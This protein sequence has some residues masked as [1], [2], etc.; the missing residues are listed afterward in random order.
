MNEI[1]ILE[2]QRELEK[3][4][5]PT[6][7]AISKEI[8]SFTKGNKEKIGKIFKRLKKNE[9]WEYIKGYT[10]FKGNKILV[11]KNVLIPRI[12]TEQLV[13]IA[14][15]NIG[16]IKGEKQIFDI[17]TGSSCI[18]ISLSKVF[19]EDIFAIDISKK[20]VEVAKKN[21]EVNNCKNI[22]LVN[23]NLLDFDFNN[24]VPTVIIANL[25]Y[26]PSRSIEKLDPSVK[27]YE[28]ISALD[29]GE[30]GHF[31]YTK[32]LEQI[33]IKNINLKYAIFEIDPSIAKYFDSSN[34]DI[35]KDIF[36][37]KRFA[38]IRPFPLK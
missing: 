20:A 24:K 23:T 12:E 9:P 27:K 34:F 16:E 6:P 25:P 17:G 35:K 3:L 8:V 21:I 37:R 30:K 1:L 22:K 29:G 14:I 13:D 10:Y 33:K 11:N 2:I 19:K 18:A 7:L 36:G 32:L 4:K 5:Y 31:F 26:L 38:I 15:E 28:P